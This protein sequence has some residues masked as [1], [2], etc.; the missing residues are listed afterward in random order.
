MS[1]RYQ[2]IIYITIPAMKPQ[3]LFGAVMA[4]VNAFSAGTI[5]V[6]LSGRIRLP[7]TP[8]R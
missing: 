6:A 4:I 2:E 3:M 1:N 7:I 5:G 8:V